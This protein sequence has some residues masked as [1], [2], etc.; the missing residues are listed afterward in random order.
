MR[1]E[2]LQFFSCG[3]F[4]SKQSRR[5]HHAA[6]KILTGRYTESGGQAPRIEGSPTPIFTRALLS[7][8]HSSSRPFCQPGIDIEDGEHLC[9]A[10]ELMACGSTSIRQS[11]TEILMTVAVIKPIL[12]HL[13]LGLADTHSRGIAHTGS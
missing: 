7:M 8:L 13:P 2:N 4:C 9:M 3:I 6:L 12:R 5:N 1:Q 10:K 11:D